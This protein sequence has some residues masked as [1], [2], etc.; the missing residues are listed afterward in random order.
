MYVDA[1]AVRSGLV[2]ILPSLFF[3]CIRSSPV[4]N[5]DLGSLEACITV[6]NPSILPWVLGYPPPS[7]TPWTYRRGRIHVTLSSWT[8]LCVVAH[9]R[10]LTKRIERV[11]HARWPS[12]VWSQWMEH[13][14]PRACPSV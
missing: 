6:L 2:L 4:Q 1:L 13:F 5:S 11:V 3:W 7:P 12:F 10:S 8:V 9:A 14:F